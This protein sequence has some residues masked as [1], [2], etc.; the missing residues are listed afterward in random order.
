MLKEFVNRLVELAA[1]SVHEFEGSVYSSKALVHVMDKKPM[2]R[3]IEL[4]GLDSVC[5]L[6]RNEVDHVALQ[7]FI[8]VKDRWKG[9]YEMI[10]FSCLI[11]K[12]QGR[13]QTIA[14]TKRK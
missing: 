14:S 2:P 4:T 6:V 7:V 10:S 5:K 12:G 8:Q 9:L 3:A 13:S 11:E 1:P